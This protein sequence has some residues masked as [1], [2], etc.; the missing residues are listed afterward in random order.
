MGCGRRRL[1]VRR[2]RQP[3]G[4]PHW[5]KIRTPGPL[6]FIVG[7]AIA[8]SAELTE[9]SKPRFAYL[10]RRTPGERVANAANV[11][12]WRRFGE[13]RQKPIALDDGRSERVHFC[14]IA[15]RIYVAGSELLTSAISPTEKISS[16]RLDIW[17]KR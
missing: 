17:P 16:L 5:S 7:P 13:Y 6:D 10:A 8:R 4:T 11:E 1:R 2:R 3:V 14:G 12:T 15:R 9:I